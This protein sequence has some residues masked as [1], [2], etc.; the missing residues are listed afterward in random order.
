M[1]DAHQIFILYKTVDFLDILDPGDQVMAD[2]G[3]KVKTNVAMRQCTLC[4]PPR[5]AS[6]SQMLPRDIK[7]TSSIA[8]SR[9][10]VEQAIKRIRF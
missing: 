2:R 4:I 5:A 7:E 1:E 8:D 6:G 10:Y 9:I 3:F